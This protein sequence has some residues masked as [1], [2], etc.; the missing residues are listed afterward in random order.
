MLLRK[1]ADALDEIAIGGT[2]ASHH[3]AN[4]RN[5]GEG[6][7]V[8]DLIEA[9]HIDMGEFEALEFAAGL[10]HSQR[11]LERLV[12][13]GDIP[14]AE[15]D[16]ISIEALVGESQRLGIADGEAALRA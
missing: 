1:P 2:I 12:D 13:M 6:I 5:G 16:R 11:F 3:F 15:G 14:D 8:I 10:E 4:G 7:G 9:R